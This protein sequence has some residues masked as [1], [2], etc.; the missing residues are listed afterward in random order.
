V[1]GEAITMGADEVARSEKV[2]VVQD[3]KITHWEEALEAA[4][5]A[6]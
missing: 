6:V 5:G 4:L 2:A 3:G 1:A